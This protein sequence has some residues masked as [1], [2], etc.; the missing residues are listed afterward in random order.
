MKIFQLLTP[1]IY[2]LLI[3]MW[4]YILVFYLRRIWKKKM[5]GDLIIVLLVILAIEAFR[6]LFESIYFGAWYSSLMGLIPDAIYT[7]LVRPEMVFVPKLFNVI[8]ALLIIII[9]NRW[10]IPQEKAHE[11]E[12]QAAMNL[13]T[14]ELIKS[15]KELQAEII[16]REM[17]EAELRKHQGYLEN[18]VKDRT[19]A[20]S[21]VNEQLKKEIAANR[22]SEIMLKNSNSE[23]NQIFNCTADGMRVV[24]KDYKVLKVNQTFL[25]IARLGENDSTDRD[26]HELFDSPGCHTQNCTLN[27]ILGGEEY[28]EMEFE[29]KNTDGSIMPV[30][31][32]ATPYRDANG[33]LLGV[34]ETFKDITRLK[35]A[36]KIVREERDLFIEGSVVVFKWRN[37]E[38][39]P[40]EY[41]S[42]NVGQ[43]LGYPAQEFT[44]QQVLY[45]DLITREDIQQVRDRK[46]RALQMNHDHIDHSPYRVIHKD[47]R[48]LW[49]LDH[50]RFVKNAQD[51]VDYFYGYIID[52]TSY[53]ETEDKLE[54]HAQLAHTGRLTALGEMASGMAHEL[55]QPMTVVRLAADGLNAYFAEKDPDSLEAESVDDMISQIKRATSIIKN[56]RAFSRASAGPLQPVNIGESV[57]IALSFFKEQFRIHQIKLNLA[58]DLDLPKVQIDPQKFEQIV[59]NFVSNGR[60]ALQKKNEY[61]G[62]AYKM[63]LSVRLFL[64]EDNKN[65]VFEVEDNGVGMSQETR[66]R[67]LEPF[68]TTK[69]VGDGT[70]LGLSIVHGI[71]Q[72]FNMQMEIDSLEGEKSIFRILIPIVT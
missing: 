12:L 32:T 24:S 3:V 67:C 13:K 45:T 58:I 39:W 35:Q 42:P 50:T 6:N 4:L 10:W 33:N 40:V 41:V 64:S 49:L 29:R 65:V 69:K 43:V 44:S 37:Q 59:V 70:G 21:Q 46:M 53:K 57:D 68:Y 55:N 62:S 18:L 52:I 5:A 51:R 63:E 66:D 56:M 2:W 1:V 7:F 47:G 54:Q 28:V 36:E 19:K 9:L 11:A 15:N 71:V 27:R 31:L 38:G 8:A 48:K 23:L 60:Y 22:Q 34:I 61:A 16:K 72:E 30:I 25:R 20:I 14:H 17:A 26:C